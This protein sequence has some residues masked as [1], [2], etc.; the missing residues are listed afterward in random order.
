[1]R[2]CKAKDLCV[3]VAF[4][5]YSSLASEAKAAENPWGANRA[6]LRSVKETRWENNPRN[7]LGGRFK[8]EPKTL[9]QLPGFGSAR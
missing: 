2:N 8:I 9:P 3:P 4:E 1:M 7:Q 5:T 6:H